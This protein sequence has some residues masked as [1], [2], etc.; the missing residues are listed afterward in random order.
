MTPDRGLVVVSDMNHDWLT[1][2]A[3]S[4]RQRAQSVAMKEYADEHHRGPLGGL[5]VP[6][7][8]AATGATASVAVG[9]AVLRRVVS[10][11]RS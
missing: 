1:R 9:V 4:E 11:L 5:G 10:R 7:A 6:L 8:I 3:L 2:L